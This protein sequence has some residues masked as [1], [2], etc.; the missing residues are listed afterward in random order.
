VGSSVGY[1]VHTFDAQTAYEANQAAAQYYTAVA[2]LA[3]APGDASSNGTGPQFA[4]ANH[5]HARE[6]YTTLAAGVN[7]YIGFQSANLSSAT[8]IAGS[9]PNNTNTPPITYGFTATIT[10]A[11]AGA[12]VTLPY[13]MP[14]ALMSA[15]CVNGD[16][17]AQANTFYE[18]SYPANT[19]SVTVFTYKNSI[20]QTN[21]TYR[22]NFVVT[23]Y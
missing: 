1:V 22:C 13:A 14:N 20:L 8:P 10:A 7:P 19:T 21:S 3:S 15:V 17:G 9:V 2:P 12:V 4:Y 5:K 6:S 18:L 16:H 11:T 23:G